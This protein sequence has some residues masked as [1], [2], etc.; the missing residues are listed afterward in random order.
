MAPKTSKFDIADYLE[1]ESDIAEYLSEALAL[2]DPAYFQ[3]ALG[4]V[5]RAKGMAAIAKKTGLGRQSLYKALSEDGN[6][7]FA[8]VT[9]VLAAVGVKISAVPAEGKATKGRTRRHP[10]AA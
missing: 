7:E 5:A 6:P 8:T 2:D 10:R 9:K 1:S 3:H 4:A